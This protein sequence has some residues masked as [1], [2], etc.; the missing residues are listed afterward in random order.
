MSFDPHAFSAKTSVEIFSSLNALVSGAMARAQASADAEATEAAM[1]EWRDLTTALVAL[2]ARLSAENAQAE[3]AC[4]A[5]LA[6]NET[7]AAEIEA[8][9]A[10]AA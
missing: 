4:R 6:T 1:A 10:I 2:V 9:E 8:L 5:L 7:L 3:Q